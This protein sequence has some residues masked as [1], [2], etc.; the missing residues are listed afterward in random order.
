M[1]ITEATRSRSGHSPRTRSPC[2][3]TRS[4]YHSVL[5]PMSLTPPLMRPCDFR[6]CSA[7]ETCRVSRPS[8]SA[9]GSGASVGYSGISLG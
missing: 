6:R 8:I 9:N 5:R 1:P 2:A 7:S 3:V 4:W